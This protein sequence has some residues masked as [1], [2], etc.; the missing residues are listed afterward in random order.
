MN[1]RSAPLSHFLTPKFIRI[2][3]A[4]AV[5]SLVALGV[6]Y[7]P[8][9]ASS[10]ATKIPP[11]T[12]ISSASEPKRTSM[13]QNYAL[14]D[15]TDYAILSKPLSYL[16][17]GPLES[18]AADRTTPMFAESVTLYAA[19]CVTPKTELNLGETVCA[20]TD[21]IDL[22]VPNNHYMNWIDS[23]LNQTNGG[24]I[25]QNP[26][27]F[28]F[29]PPTTGTWKATVGR[30]D[31]ADSSIIGNPPLFTVSSGT[32]ISTYAPNCLTP[33]TTFTLGETVCAK[34]SGVDPAFNRRFA[35]VDPANNIRST[36]PIN[37]DSQTDTFLLSTDEIDLTYGNDNRGVW[38]ALVITSRGSVVL[39]ARFMVQ[40]TEPSAD[41]SIGQG[42]V[43]T[44]PTSGDPTT[45]SVSVFNRGPNDAENVVITDQTPANA[46][47][48]SVTQTS[49]S[50]FSCTGSTTVTCTSSILKA[51]DT[52]IF[53]FVYTAGSAGST[54]T[55]TASVTSD[56]QELNNADNSATD[57][58]YTIVQGNGDGGGTCTVACPDDITTPAN[59]NQGGQDGAIV[60]FSLPSG[61]EECGTITT[62][63]C[64]DC[65]F[66]EGT[67]VVT[68]TSTTGDSCSFTVTVTATGSAPTI[69]CPGDKTGNA[70]S[71]CQATFAL[72]TATASGNNV[73]VVAFRSDGKPVYTCDEF[74]NCTRNSTDAP[75]NVG[76][77]TVTWF[78]YAHDIPG[79]YNAATGDEESHRTG[80]A[81]CVQTVIVND[82]TPP[83]IAAT[84]TTVAADASCQ[85]AVPDFSN[86][87]S[88]NCACSASDDSE[89]CQNHSDIA[90]SQTPAAGTMLPLGSYN[91]HIEANDGANNATKD[92]TLTVADQTAPQISC[93]SDITVY[94]PLNT[95]DTSMVVNFNVTGSDN[96]STPTITTN[97]PA[98]N[99][100]PVGTTTVTA[101]ANDGNGNTASCSF[102]V[103]VL[104]NFF[105]FFSPVDNLPVFNEMKAGRSVPVKFSLSG[106]KGLNIFAADSPNSVQIACDTGAP[107]AE[108]EETSTAGSSNLTYD[109]TS[110][111]YHYVWKT[112]SAWANTCRQL[113]VVLNDGTTHS[114]KFKFKP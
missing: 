12:K 97:A 9:S 25:T 113:N 95:P 108:V 98:G 111:R 87:V 6:S 20:K 44:L 107:V 91:V 57:G 36:T 78:A 4:A 88:D 19:D 2:S 66:P 103:T 60:H 101:T 10:H 56:T 109:A 114:A 3:I 33:Q 67:T 17:D 63:H 106:N 68:A 82:V 21:G 13:V 40:A 92:I 89:E 80:S 74:G 48:V 70:G 58:P 93:P 79:P 84:N 110:D 5:L 31:P 71:N 7:S 49:G 46:T 65:F 24:T 96:C 27:Y 43:G 100:F 37:T 22:S 94:L 8:R 62:D 35:W 55:N 90:Y 23:Q 102:N 26:Q 77:T 54:I 45:F 86:M 73:T 39:T 42:L 38:R 64:N 30:V 61:N 1:Q 34:V 99:V 11:Q 59:T 75:F 28:L 18:F 81:T 69:S 50:G 41:L 104:Y 15:V 85:A 14:V 51:R 47:L 105:G 29:V 112:E 72:G 53:E 83:T 52:A 16:F 76:T 32:A